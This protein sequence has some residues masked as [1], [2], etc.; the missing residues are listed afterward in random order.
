MLGPLETSVEATTEVEVAFA[1]VEAA[2]IRALVVVAFVVALAASRKV[3]E[4]APF[5]RVEPYSLEAKWAFKV[6]VSWASVLAA[7]EQFR[8][9]MVIVCYPYLQYHME[10]C[11]F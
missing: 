4:V 7:L 5:I 11:T 1:L 8:I 9:L 2:F 10:I 6:A 3:E